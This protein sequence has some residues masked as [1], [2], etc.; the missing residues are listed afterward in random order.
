MMV[1]NEPHYFPLRL[2][3]KAWRW[4]A[5]QAGRTLLATFLIWG[6]PC[7]HCHTCQERIICQKDN[8]DL[9]E[10]EETWIIK[11]YPRPLQTGVRKECSTW[12]LMTRGRSFCSST[13]I[14]VESCSSWHKNYE[15]IRPDHYNYLSFWFWDNCI[16]LCSWRKHYREISC[17]LYSDAP[18]ESIFH[19]YSTMWQPQHPH[20]R[21]QDTQHCVHKKDST[22]RPCIATTTFLTFPLHV[23]LSSTLSLIP[24]DHWSDLHFNNLVISRKSYEGN[25]TLLDW[26]FCSRIIFW[27][28]IQIVMYINTVLLS[29]AWWYFMYGRTTVCVIIY[30]PKGNWGVSGFWLLQ[31][32]AM[33]SLVSYLVLTSFFSFLWN[34]YP[35]MQ[36]LDINCRFSIF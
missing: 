34:K 27:R 7:K 33:N 28:V 2:I 1:S 26:F 20:Q 10:P 29:I 12:W 35:G 36:W 30:L 8:I 21:S 32:K 17:P 9:K 24:D 11:I 22:S 23:L 5:A 16:F 18:S 25:H 31:K 6:V 4:K 14:F 19:I 3:P 15:R 13:G